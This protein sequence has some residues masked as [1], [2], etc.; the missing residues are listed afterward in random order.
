MLNVELKGCGTNGHGT[1]PPSP[2]IERDGGS[3]SA[4]QAPYFWKMIDVLGRDVQVLGPAHVEGHPLA[5]AFLRLLAVQ[6]A[7]RAVGVLLLSLLAGIRAETVF[8][9][10]V[11]RTHA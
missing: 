1:P 10:L 9:D 7:A 6:V 5:S 11:V 4:D 8:P 3:I 2:R